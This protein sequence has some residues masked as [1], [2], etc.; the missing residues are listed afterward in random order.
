[1]PPP[2]HSCEAGLNPSRKESRV[3]P[4]QAIVH[5]AAEG[6]GTP[7][8]F[9]ADPLASALGARLLRADRA[10]GQV[11]LEFTPGAAFLQGE[12]VVQGGAVSAMLDFATAC[13]A[14]LVLEAGV[15]CA[16]VTLTTSFL[17]PV[18]A[19]PCIVRAEVERQGRSMVF[20]RA[21]LQEAGGEARTLATAVAALAVVRAR[22]ST[23]AP[24]S[25][26]PHPVAA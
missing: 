24:A 2:S 25:A 3:S 4:N 13:A 21:R 5:Q 26:P 1:M 8:Q 16:T 15:D 11:Q 12:G 9:P 7:P 14:M 6:L 19:G 23:S 10:T 17:R 20:T 22:A 18:L